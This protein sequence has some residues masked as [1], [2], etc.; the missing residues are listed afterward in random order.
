MKDA[1][2]DAI[3]KGRKV[4]QVVQTVPVWGWNHFKG[5]LQWTDNRTK[6]Y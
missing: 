2:E 6:Y 3:K 4:S 5:P 1:L